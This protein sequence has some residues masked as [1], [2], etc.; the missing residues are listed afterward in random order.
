ML[1]ASA[2]PAAAE[3]YLTEAQAL[4]VIFGDTAVVRREQR[5]VDPQLRAKLEHASNLHF[6]E[7]TC[8]FF[9]SGQPGQPQKYALVMNEI[10]KTEPITFMVGMNDQGKVTDVVIMEF[11]ENRGWEVKEKRFLNQFHGKT[12]HSSIRVDEDIINYT[13]ATLSSKAVARGVK[14]ALFLLD[15][16]YPPEARHQAPAASNF[17]AS[18]EMSA[19]I[20]PLLTVSVPDGS[21][22]LFRQVRYAMGTACE[23]R[24]WCW[25]AAAAQRAFREGFAEIERVEQIFSAYRPGSELSLVNS[26]AAE[27]ATPVSAEFAYFTQAAIRSWHSSSGMVDISV[28]PLMR[29]W[30]F[31]QGA[32]RLPAQIEI[33]ATRKLVGC[34]KLRLDLRANTL[35]FLKNGMQL[36]FGGLAKGYAAQ[37]AAAR[38]QS[39]GVIS[40]LVN[41]GRSSLAASHL[42]LPSDPHALESAPS[43]LASWPIAICDPARDR[44][45]AGHLSL[46]SGQ[47]LSTSGTNERQFVIGKKLFSHILNPL[48]GWPLQG[49][50]SVTAVSAFGLESEVFAKRLLIRAS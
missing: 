38:I 2:V 28:A 50:R 8:T 37:I 43:I 5:S 26:Q 40:A 41:L 46:P 12:V 36:D 35:R 30:G 7:P 31:H 9:I 47:C 19:A 29:L 1:A 16:F 6:P 4:G 15:A 25:T 24:A 13:G 44:T 49:L 23:I 21:I 22:S 11:R 18:F 48:T 39:T 20:T 33:A 34:D 32:P 42:A 27:R 3:V 10:G 14:R 45:C 17:P